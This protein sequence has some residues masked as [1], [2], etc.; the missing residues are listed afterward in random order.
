MYYYYYCIGGRSK[1][2]TMMIF[3]GLRQ[4]ALTLGGEMGPLPFGFKNKKI[5]TA[6]KP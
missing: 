6:M 4:P 2:R 3:E 5:F 1:K